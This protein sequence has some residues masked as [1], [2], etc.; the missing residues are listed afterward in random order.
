MLVERE[1]LLARVGVPDLAGAVVA[2]RDEPRAALVEGAV[3]QR[4][5]VC[6]QH[7]EEAEALHLILLL[8]LDKLL[9]ELLE[10]RL[11]CLR[12]ERLLEQN[13][14]DQAINVSPV[15]SK[16]LGSDNFIIPA[17][18]VSLSGYSARKWRE[19]NAS[20]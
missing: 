3:G 18:H 15:T 20:K 2:A 7:L 11:A 4:E 5:Q 10:L 16:K 13:L 19:I 17:R 12:D 1:E 8:L 9:D 6:S 14:I